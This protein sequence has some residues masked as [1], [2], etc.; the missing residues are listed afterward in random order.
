MANEKSPE[1]LPTDVVF[2]LAQVLA[3]RKKKE[4]S[5]LNLARQI[6]LVNGNPTPWVVDRRKL[7]RIVE[8]DPN[9]PLSPLELVALDRYL[10]RFNEGLAQKPLLERP[11]ILET[12]VEAGE[13]TFL[14]GARARRNRVDISNWDVQAMA[15]ILRGT[16]GFRRT[17]FDIREVLL[18]G[19]RSQVENAYLK[20]RRRMKGTW[21]ELLAEDGP[22][23]VC[24][25]S[26]RSC[27]AAEVLL[28]KM[29]GEDAFV[30]SVGLHPRMPFHFVW[31]GGEESKIPCRFEIV[32]EDLAS[33]HASLTE[34]VLE[35]KARVL[36]VGDEP[37]LAQQPGE[38]GS[39]T[40]YGIVAAQRRPGGQIWMVIA[41][42]TGAAT[43]AAARVVRKIHSNLPPRAR[44]RRSKV[45]WVLVKSISKRGRSKSMPQL[46]IVTDCEIVGE[47][48]TFPDAAG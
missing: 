6:N 8:E 38:T 31:V 21:L 43:H 41:G 16:A 5:Y 25:G 48:R 15:E 26:P 23:L 37:Y 2:R 33:S 46:R 22:S 36:M 4:G 40:S 12:L 30:S 34:Q 47:L 32:A 20:P 18:L 3:E 28:A 24:C 35:G 19:D 7:A 44:G 10:E 29:F 14:L 11:S 9:V 27:H 17:H 45:F 13:V 39:H 1:K 42:L